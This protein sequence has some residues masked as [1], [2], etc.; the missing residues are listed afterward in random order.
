MNAKNPGKPKART[1]G[2]KNAGQK[3][4]AMRK[5]TPVKNKPAKS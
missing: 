4:S 5:D 2:N 3:A 1:A